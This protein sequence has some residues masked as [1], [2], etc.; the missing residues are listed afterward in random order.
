MR[1]LLTALAAL[2]LTGCS[3]ADFNEKAE[4]SHRVITVVAESVEQ[5][6]P[7]IAG[8]EAAVGPTV[9]EEQKAT[10]VGISGKIESGAKAIAG[11]A[12]AI[13]GGEGVGLILGAIG[14]LA[15]A[16]ST[17][18]ARR[19]TKKLAVAAVNAAD[20]VPGGGKALVDAAKAVDVGDMVDSV[21]KRTL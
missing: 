11:V 15:G 8:I 12:A 13:P 20:T 1:I 21:Y 16:L 3:L 6:E 10:S 14:T 7:V 17:V 2:M 9:T 5:A 18:M 4:T 19:K